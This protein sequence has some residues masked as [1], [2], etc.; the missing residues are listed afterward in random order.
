M[1]GAA[2]SSLITPSP[3]HASN[4]SFPS[5]SGVLNAERTPSP[6]IPLAPISVSNTSPNGGGKGSF[7]RNAQ[8]GNSSSTS[9][10]VCHQLS[11]NPKNHPVSLD[12]VQRMSTPGRHLYVTILYLWQVVMPSRLPT[13]LP[14]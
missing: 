7:S 11:G 14:F 1:G 6:V 3:F 13:R 9:V 5:S 12:E 4:S 8:K 10:Y 2:T